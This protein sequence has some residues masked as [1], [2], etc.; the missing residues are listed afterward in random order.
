MLWSSTFMV[1]A[2]SRAMGR[3]QTS[4][5][6]AN[7]RHEPQKRRT[8]TVF[9]RAIRER[10]G[11]ALSAC[12]LGSD[13]DASPRRVG[14]APLLTVADEVKAVLGTSSVPR[15]AIQPRWYF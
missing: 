5:V 2:Y 12:H 9:I 1:S 14:A 6:R 7:R 13:D 4:R 3:L 15:V 11:A 8:T 10:N